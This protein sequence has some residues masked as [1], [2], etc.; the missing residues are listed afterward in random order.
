MYKKRKFFHN[1]WTDTLIW[2]LMTVLVVTGML[3]YN[4]FFDSSNNQQFKAAAGE[5]D[6]CFLR[7][8]LEKEK[9]EICED[10]LSELVT[11]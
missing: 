4:R 11:R 10:I 8:S 7:F 2:S 6:Y 5:S 9:Y 1:G 3:V